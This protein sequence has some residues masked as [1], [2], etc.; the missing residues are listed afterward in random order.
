MEALGGNGYIEECPLPRLYREA[1]VNS[2]WEGSGNVICLDVIR[3]ARRE[4]AAIDALLAELE[5]ARGAN[6]DLD[7]FVADL[8]ESASNGEDQASARVFAQAIALAFT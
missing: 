7:S 6:R 5:D 8:R 2:I 3:A 1:P 4:P